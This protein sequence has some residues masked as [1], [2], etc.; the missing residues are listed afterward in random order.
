MKKSWR[1]QGNREASKLA[2]SSGWGLAGVDSTSNPL[3]SRTRRAKLKKDDSSSSSDDDDE[4]ERSQQEP[5]TSVL[6]FDTTESMSPSTMTVDTT[7]ST[8]GGK[9]PAHSRVILDIDKMTNLME[10]NIVCKKCKGTVAVTF[11][12]ATIA[13]GC[14]IQCRNDLCCFVDVERVLQSDREVPDNEYQS[15]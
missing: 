9:K 11:P 2:A 8:A 13:S 10:R 15:N 1:P 12:T 14:R 6:E 3:V 4:E 7:S 5:P